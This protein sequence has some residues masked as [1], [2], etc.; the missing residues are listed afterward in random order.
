MTVSLLVTLTVPSVLVPSVLVKVRVE[1][2]AKSWA[3]SVHFGAVMTE[4]AAAS[5][6][7]EK[8][9][10]PGCAVGP[11]VAVTLVEELLAAAVAQVAGLVSAAAAVARAAKA[12]FTSR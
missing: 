10:E 2:M 6:F 4:C 8:V 7:T 3:G 9:S 11:A 12:L 5:C 1:P